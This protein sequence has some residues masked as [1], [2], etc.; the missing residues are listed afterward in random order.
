MAIAELGTGGA[1]NFTNY[2]RMAGGPGTQAS[3]TTHRGE[4]M[5]AW[6]QAT[7][8]IEIMEFQVKARKCFLCDPKLLKELD[9]Q[10]AQL[11]GLRDPGPW[12]PRRSQSGF[13]DGILLGVP[14]SDQTWGNIRTGLYVVG[15]TAAVI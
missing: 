6:K 13:L 12:N 5:D 7:S 1:V 8:C 4:F 14:G 9:E 11:G 2:W 3:W 15:G 10:K